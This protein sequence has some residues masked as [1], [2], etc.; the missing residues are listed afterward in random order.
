[1]QAACH[2]LAFAT[3][4]RPALISRLY[5]SSAPQ[6][7]CSNAHTM[8]ISHLVLLVSLVFLGFFGRD[9]DEYQ[10]SSYVRMLHDLIYKVSICSLFRSLRKSEVFGEN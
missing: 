2:C 10:W 9:F 8:H 6:V 7:S 3:S 5:A 4:T 1:M